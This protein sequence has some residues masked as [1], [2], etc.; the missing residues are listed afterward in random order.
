M[1][2]LLSL[3]VYLFLLLPARSQLQWGFFGG[4]Q[5][6]GARYFINNQKQSTSFKQG[7][8]LGVGCKVPFQH[9]LYFTPAFFYSLKGYKVNFT[10][11]VYPPDSLAIDNNTTIHTVELTPLLDIDLSDQPSHF[12]FRFGPSLDFQIHGTE[13]Y[14][15]AN[16]T[17]V[18]HTMKIRTD[19]D[20]GFV[21]AN[22]I[23]QL[24]FETSKGFYILAHYSH[25]IGSINNED[26]GPR[27][28]HQALS[29]ILG[30]YFNKEKV[31]SL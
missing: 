12:F 13:K 15:L 14:H 19:G 7:F 8:N 16:G 2:K 24:G 1:Q 21:G 20:Y 10:Q 23:G 28:Y 27:I 31:F 4:P 22:L 26:R 6:T 11:Y 5:M 3:S 29:L 30:F 9:R 17:L 25:G 18:T